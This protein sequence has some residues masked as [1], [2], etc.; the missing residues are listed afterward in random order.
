MTVEGGGGD[1]SVSFI[2]LTH[3]SC[4]ILFR[5]VNENIF[6]HRGL[7]L[8]PILCSFRSLVFHEKFSHFLNV[9]QLTDSSD[10]VGGGLNCLQEVYSLALT[11]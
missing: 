2:L 1:V 4:G 9:H 6:R 10:G 11:P 7:T 3:L 5:S 8:Q